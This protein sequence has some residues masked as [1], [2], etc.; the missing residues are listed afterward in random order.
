MKIDA[1]RGPSFK[2]W[3]VRAIMDGEKKQ[4]RRVV[5]LDDHERWH[6]EYIDTEHMAHFADSKAL[7]N[8]DDERTV[9]LPYQPDQWYYLREPLVKTME[10]NPS[11]ANP[12]C[13]RE[14][15]DKVPMPMYEADEQVL[16]GT[17]GWERD[18]LPGIFMPK[19]AARLFVQFSVRV[20]R[21]QDIS[22]DDAL[23]EGIRK[24][25]DVHHAEANY[26]PIKAFSRV[27]ND[28]HDEHTWGDNPWV[29]VYTIE[30]L[31]TQIKGL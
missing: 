29:F 28:I 24:H 11:K 6:F 9:G 12:D 27:W 4:T 3:G 17:W 25:P 26:E 20:E 16:I 10:P 15:P 22:E 31:K 30:Q 21:L 23:A 18:R 1:K 14:A 8:P 2:L 5:P 13:P 7:P 19:A